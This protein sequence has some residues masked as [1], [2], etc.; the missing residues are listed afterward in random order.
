MYALFVSLGIIA[1]LLVY[2]YEARKIQ[3]N[4]EKTLMIVIGAVIGSAVGAKLLEFLL[5]IDR[6]QSGNDLLV[7]LFSGRTI[8]GGLIGGTIGVWATKKML[9]IRAKR[10]NLFAPAIALGVCIGR[11]GCF[12]NGCCYGK[13]TSLPWATDFGDGVLRHPTQIYESL[14]MLA[15][16]FIIKFGF[17]NKEVAP[18]FLFNLLMIAYFSFRFLIEFIRTE[19]IA[20]FHL[21]YFQIICIFVL[22]YLII[23]TFYGRRKQSRMG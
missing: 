12:F 16:F 3:K 8:V 17:K 20:F 22:I 14:F 6:L 13:P 1:G 18:G 21:T 9:N 11:L 2:F 5:N 15:M 10:G 4:D 19:R 7:F 23:T